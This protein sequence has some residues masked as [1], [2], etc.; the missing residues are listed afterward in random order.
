MSK[1]TKNQKLAVE[2]IEAGKAYSLKEAEA[3]AA[4]ADYVGLESIL[5][6]LK[7]VGL[8]LT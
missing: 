7:V 4:G 5:K 6:R 2:K 1:L 3:T 8:T